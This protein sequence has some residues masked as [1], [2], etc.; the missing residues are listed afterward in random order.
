VQA[1]DSRGSALRGQ[2]D[3]L[4]GHVVVVV[5]GEERSLPSDA[6]PCH[7][8]MMH[9]GDADGLVQDVPVKPPQDAEFP[10]NAGA[11]SCPE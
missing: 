5:Q 11:F 6:S 8:H 2:I 4:D 1:L 3:M 9:E 10:Q 7:Q